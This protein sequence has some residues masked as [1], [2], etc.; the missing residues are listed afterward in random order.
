MC[1]VT[2]I[3]ST[4]SRG[5]LNLKIRQMS[6]AISYR[7]PD[8]DGFWVNQDDNV[9]LGHRRLSIIDLSETGTQPMISPSGRYVMSY[10][11]EIYNYLD[12]KNALKEKGYEFRGKSDTEVL[13]CAFEEYGIKE[14]LTKVSGMFAIILWDRKEK[15]I[16]LIRDFLGKKP[17]YVGWAGTDL[18]I[19]SE[20]KAFHTHPDFKAI[21]N[22]DHLA[23]YFKYACVPAPHSIYQNVWQLLPGSIMTLP[24]RALSAGTCLL[25]SMESYWDAADIIKK[26]APQRAKPRDDK[27]AIDDFEELLSKCV[28]ERMISDV[29]LGAFLSGGIDSSAIVALMQKQSTRPIKTYSVGFN[30]EGFNEAEFAKQV[31]NHLGTDHH[32]LYLSPKDALD[33]IPSL[34]QIYDEPFADISQ[35]PT[36]LVSKFAREHVTVALS[37]DGGDEMLGGYRRHF[38][39]PP[40]WN[41]MKYIPHPLRRLGAGAINSI[42]A[43]SWNR[44]GAKKNHPHLADSMDKFGGMMRQKTSTDVYDYLLGFWENPYEIVLDAKPVDLHFK[45]KF[46]ESENLSF[47]EEMMMCDSISYLPNDILQKVDRASMAVSLEARAPLLDRR[48]FEH[49]WTLPEHLKIRDGK[50]KWLLREVLARHV[51]REMWDRPK[52]GFSPP[53][54]PWLRG[55]LRDWAESYLSV[56]ALEEAGLNAKPIR[57]TWE[58]HLAGRRNHSVRLWSVLMYQAWREKY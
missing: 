34:A 27:Q 44:I 47:A 2:G 55:E 26:S 18:V 35:I 37:G 48:I 54:G 19:S 50:G 46:L 51:P 49:V 5:K 40:M 36:Y 16:A 15:T 11:G 23:L 56:Q 43:D 39:V 21:T 3:F 30:V 52:K 28:S 22:Q 58:D 57:K 29:P 10:N 1:G 25:S 6:D 13:L 17:L 12:I 53:L 38:M 7:G 14:T 31:A 32:E 33:V 42:S 8:G 9:A 45:Q 24:I 4:T 41:K 20:L